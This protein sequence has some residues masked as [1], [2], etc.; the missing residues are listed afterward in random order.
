MSGLFG[1]STKVIPEFTGLQVNTAVQVLPI[2]IIYGSPRTQINVI[3]YNGFNVQNVK[4][5]GKGALTGGKGGTQ[6]EYFATFIGA[7]GEGP[8][9][10]VLLIY[11][12]Q[13]VWPPGE[14][15]SNGA[16]Y[17]DGSA[18]QAPW[19][20]VVHNWPRDA[21]PY[22]YTS[23]YAFANAQIDSSATIPQLNMILNGFL[24][25][26]SPLNDSTLYITTGQYDSNGNPLS[27]MGNFHLGTCDADPGRVI[28]DFLTNDRYGATFPIQWID[29]GTLLSS[30]QAFDPNIGDQAISTY[31]QAVGF[32]WSDVINN[33]EAANSV[34]ERWCKNIQVAPIWNGAYLRFIPYWD[35][36][37]GN[38]PHWS[39]HNGIAK[40]YF[41]PY[42]IPVTQI[43][44]DHILQSESK[45]EHPISFIRKDPTEVY[46]TVRIDFKDRNNAFNDNT[47]EAKDEAHIELFGP[48]VDNI[49][50]AKEFSLMTYA[51]TAVHIALRRNLSI[52]LTYTWKMGPLWAWLDPMDI[53]QIPDPTNTGAFVNVRIISIED[54]DNEDVTIIAE[55]FPLGAQAPT[56]VDATETTPPTLGYMNVPSSTAYPPVIFEPTPAMLTA[57]SFAVP[58]VIIGASGGNGPGYEGMLDPNWGGCFIWVSLDGVNYQKLGELVGPSTIGL[59]SNPLAAFPGGGYDST[60]TL[61]VNLNE[62]NGVLSSVTPTAA[63]AGNSICCVKDNTGFEIIGY[64]NATLTAPYTYALTGLYRGMYGTVSK[65]FSPGAQFLYSGSL[66]NNFETALPP[67]YAVGQNFWVKLQS[68]NSMRNF[69]EDLSTVTAYQYIVGGA[70]VPPPYPVTMI[71]PLRSR[72][73]GITP[74]AILPTPIYRKYGLIP[75]PPYVP[76]TPYPPNLATPPRSKVKGLKPVDKPPRPIRHGPALAPAPTPPSPSLVPLPRPRIRGVKA[77]TS[78]PRI[79]RRGGLVP[80]LL[81]DRLTSATP[82][83]A[84]GLRRLSAT[85]TGPAVNIRRLSDNA[86]QDIGFIGNDFN[87]AA[88]SAFIGASTGVVAT[89]YDQSTNAS[90][91]TAQGADI[92]RQP[93]LV[94]SVTPNGKPIVRF[95]ASGTG[96][97]QG[98]TATT[99]SN[100]AVVTQ[101]AVV[102]RNGGYT[103]FSVFISFGNNTGQPGTTYANSVGGGFTVG[104]VGSAIIADVAATENVWHSAVGIMDGANTRMAVDGIAGTPSAMTG[105]TG[106]T[107]ISI[108]GLSAWI[109]LG[110]MAETMIWNGDMSNADIA[111]MYTDQHTYYG[112]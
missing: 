45:D 86:T 36:Y 99:A 84:Y 51:N 42:T 75:P 87:T 11:Q 82:V 48:R 95:S 26:T 71:A 17:F 63:A 3:Y 22:K 74:R 101:A 13:N 31:C 55:E 16:S 94:L 14:Y 29:Q 43:T 59:L 107:F 67:G 68:F 85:Y 10:P 38:N 100:Q 90:H 23:Y 97:Y 104:N 66:A 76:P 2:P 27:Y 46:N 9:G 12:D 6:V 88:F 105:G 96:G 37:N 77:P 40:K 112:Y 50:S 47:A 91:A 20:F 30:N 102:N 54:D 62:S 110:D 58:Q 80:V 19:G 69:V 21:R 35:S 32:A 5:G 108:A 98:L 49:G 72:T 52:M 1:G 61:T 92:T 60:D 64:T 79:I 78:V 73:K 57:T 93:Q 39:A 81:L 89:W 53:V 106:A 18:G 25:K 24:A 33:A 4:A 34:I 65:G 44:M 8:I 28:L 7:L 109:Y 103:N 111:T 83:A 15:P 41:N 56:I 70:Y